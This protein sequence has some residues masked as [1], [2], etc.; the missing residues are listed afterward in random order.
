MMIDVCGDR[1]RRDETT[2]AATTSKHST[3]RPSVAADRICFIGHND[4]SIISFIT[5]R[6]VGSSRLQSQDTEFWPKYLQKNTD[7]F[8]Q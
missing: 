2:D 5:C 4:S 7:S 3:V 8:I 6:I 1:R